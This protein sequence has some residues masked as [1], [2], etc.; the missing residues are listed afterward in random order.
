ML[1][2]NLLYTGVTRGKQLVVLEEAIAIA[3]RNVSGRRRWSKLAEWLRLVRPSDRNLSS[4]FALTTLTV[5]LHPCACNVQERHR[6]ANAEPDHHT[7]A[8][9][10]VD[11]DKGTAPKARSDRADLSAGPGPD[12]QHGRDA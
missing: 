3:V 9:P 7:P 11:Q 10:T 5:Q 6:G 8:V 1:Q 12:R 2:R 4:H